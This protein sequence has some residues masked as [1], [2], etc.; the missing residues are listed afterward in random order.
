MCIMGVDFK[1][2]ETFTYF[3]GVLSLIIGFFAVLFGILGSV[4]VGLD[5]LPVVIGGGFFMALSIAISICD[6][7]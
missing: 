7:N 2:M 6:K 3:V 1:H 5:S 4:E